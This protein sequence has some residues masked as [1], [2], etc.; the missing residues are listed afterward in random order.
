MT[1]ITTCPP[2]ATPARS[3]AATPVSSQGGLALIYIAE[4]AL[5]GKAYVGQTELPL[6][7]RQKKHES[8]ARE[9]RKTAFCAALRKYGAGAFHWRILARVPHW[10]ANR[11]EV[12]Y[13]RLYRTLSPSGYNL[14]TG[15]KK[16]EF[17]EESRDK[18]RGENNPAKRADVRRKISENRRGKGLGKQSPEVIESR[19]AP[20]R[21]RKRP[22]SVHRKAWETRRRA[23]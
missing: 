22:A 9:G 23:A 10:G 17:S 4:C 19:I 15:G 6:S 3:G 13:I 5:S 8:D 7:Y 20:L 12:E 16:G 14:T 21:G 11:A 18:M 1:R 2:D